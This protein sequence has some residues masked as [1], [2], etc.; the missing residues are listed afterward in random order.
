M[1]IDM[2]IMQGRLLMCVHGSAC[3]RLSVLYKENDLSYQHQTWYIRTAHGR[4]SACNDRDQKVKG[5]SHVVIK[6]AA[7]MGRPMHIDMTAYVSS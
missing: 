3:V 2:M 7:E 1:R 5:Q 4:N 6:C